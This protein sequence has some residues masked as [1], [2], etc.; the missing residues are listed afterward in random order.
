[1]NIRTL[2]TIAVASTSLATSVA[3]LVVL[4]SGLLMLANCDLLAPEEYLPADSPSLT[5]APVAVPLFSF[6]NVRSISES[7]Q[8]IVNNIAEQSTT[9]EILVARSV[10]D[11][12]T[13]LETG[14]VIINV[15]PSDA[16]EPASSRMRR[17]SS[18]AEVWEGWS[19]GLPPARIL[20]GSTGLLGVVRTQRG[21]YRIEPLGDQ[22]HVIVL[23]NEAEA[24]SEHPP[25]APVG[26]IADSLQLQPVGLDSLLGVGAPALHDGKSL[27][28]SGN[29]PLSGVPEIDVMVVYTAAAAMATGSINDLIDFAVDE[30]K[31]SYSNSGASVGLHLAHTAQV[32]YNE[33]GRTYT[34]HI[35]ALIATSDGHMDNVHTLR[36]QYLADLVV[37]VV[38]D[39]SYCGIAGGVPATT[40]TA[41]AVV[42][43]GCMVA[44]FYS[45][46]HEIGHLQGAGH[47]LGAPD[48]Y[49]PYAYG[50]GF[51]DP[52]GQWR[53]IMA[54]G[55]A[56]NWSCA[57]V[58]Y[59]SNPHVQHPVTGQWM[60]STT[61]AHNA[62]VIN[63]T[64][65]L[66]RDFRTLPQPNNFMLTNPGAA[67]ASPSF[68]WTPVT[69]ADAHYVYRCV[70]A[71]GWHYPSCF[72]V[73]GGG[74][75]YWVDTSLTMADVEPW[76]PC[77]STAY[78]YATALNRT[79]E[80]GYSHEIAVCVD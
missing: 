39:I 69:G 57:R 49:S 43:V 73:V 3:R 13:L 6:I 20:S 76:E 42:H 62:R 60:G 17:S 34:Q 35:S 29:G 14:R 30:T 58:A 44:P 7:Q 80:S 1:M 33:T 15:T 54:Y 50:H 72:F 53:T 56:C 32:V 70:S 77:P 31:Q 68:T 65:Y 64:R 28:G 10:D 40:T 51:V 36:N 23:V 5:T 11:A 27:Q 61:T 2:Y 16:F 19:A 8:R 22:Y 46:A 63:D 12:V 78:Y 55:N 74:P 18:G 26:T 79:G 37:L 66:L 9:S 71:G 52:N 25:E 4:V 75:G 38:N 45:F 59:W 47:D 21:V 41:F 24:P 67:F 48:H